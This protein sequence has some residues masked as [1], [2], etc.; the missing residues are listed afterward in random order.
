ML[1]ATTLAWR[2]A[3]GT[4]GVGPGQLLKPVGLTIVDDGA[5]LELYVRDTQNHR[6]QVFD[7][8]GANAPGVCGTFLR[9]FG[10]R[11]DAPAQFVQPSGMAIDPKGRLLVSE[12]GA[13]R[14]QMLTLQGAPLQV[15]RLPTAGKLYGMCVSGQRVFVADYERHQVHVL[16]LGSGTPSSPPTQPW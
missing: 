12:A 2:G 14:V 7:V 1:D 3:F 4:R 8:T 13:G 15:L 9:A 11:G 10:E 6:V 16:Q 5:R